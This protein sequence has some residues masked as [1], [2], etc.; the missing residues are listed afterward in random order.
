MLQKL[1]N[2]PE[3]MLHREQTV[4]HPFG[5]IKLRMGA[6][7]LLTNTRFKKRGNRNKSSCS[8]LQLQKNDGNYG[9]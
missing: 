1:K 5:T 7:H 9:S 3:F 2:E 4:E 6:T 8:A